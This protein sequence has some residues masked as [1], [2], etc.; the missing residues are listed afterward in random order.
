METSCW[1]VQVRGIPQTAEFHALRSLGLVQ[2]FGISC[3]GSMGHL[4]FARAGELWAVP[5]EGKRLV[6]ADSPAKILEGVEVFGGGMALF[7]VARDGSL[8]HATLGTRAV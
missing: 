1:F 6:V 7:S 3:A 8:V 4:V 2:R 5:F